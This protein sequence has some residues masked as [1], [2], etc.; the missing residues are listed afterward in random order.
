[1]RIGVD[2]DSTLHHYW[3]LFSEAARRRFGIDL[4]YDDQLTW[5]IAQLEPEQVAA[6]VEDTHLDAA[7][8]A[9]KPYPGAVETISRWRAE[10]HFIH[11]TS[12]RDT[13]AHDATARWLAE[14]GLPYDDLYCSWDKIS[15]C[16]EIGIELLIDDSPVNITRAL[17][18]GMHAATLAHPWNR[19]V[20]ERREVVCADDWFDLDAKLRPLL[21]P[22][23]RAA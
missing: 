8:L 3:D 1:M 21:D 14:I 2:I 17:D 12:H 19:E 23:R 11:I 13:T 20:C 18:R 16:G 6:C 7:I 10:G 4:P 5:R 22:A 9:G 15:R